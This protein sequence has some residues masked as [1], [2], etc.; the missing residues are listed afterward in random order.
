VSDQ[1]QLSCKTCSMSSMTFSIGVGSSSTSAVCHSELTGGRER[2]MLKR[3]HPLG[4]DRR[5]ATW[6]K[7]SSC[8]S[9]FL[10]STTKVLLSEQVV[11]G[12]EKAV[13][14]RCPAEIPWGSSSAEA[15]QTALDPKSS[16]CFER[17]PSAKTFASWR[18][19]SSSPAIDCC[20]VRPRKA[21][22]STRSFLRRRR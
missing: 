17:A 11:L 21:P 5:F 13:V 3:D 15:K 12:K 6:T 16:H 9:R 8:G 22:Q 1:S 10:K 7:H 18:L 14:E 20:R 19:Y 2:L 4:R